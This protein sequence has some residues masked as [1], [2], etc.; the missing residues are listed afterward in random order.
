[1]KF[2]LDAPA[3]INWFLQI[4]GK[5][6]DG[7]HDIVSAMQCVSLEDNISFEDAPEIELVSDLDLPVAEN[8]VYK[9]AALLKRRVSYR[10]GAR[11][12]LRK[13]IPHAAGLGGGSSDA[14][15]TLVGLDRLWGLNLG[16]DVLMGLGSEI[17]SDV[18]FF[19]GGSPLSVVEGRG[20]RV[21]R[22]KA[23]DPLWLLLVKPGIAIPTA[24]AYG[25]YKPELTKKSVDIKLFCH[26][27]DRKDF[28]SLQHIIGNDLEKGVFEKYGV[29][30]EIKRA[31]VD[32]GAVFASMSGSGSAVFGVF[33]SGKEAAAA[34]EHM[35][36][37]WCRVV[38]TLV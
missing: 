28:A 25:A 4:T 1:M 24:W 5:R 26:A 36:K 8:L 38:R 17:G 27:L 37:Y 32:N 21:R 16:E 15:H 14:A 22:L 13:N 23:H 10:R 19:I 11:I 2:S 20:E 31:L 6:S 3:K 7:Y 34:S 18:P 9:A 30:A 29:V 33:P 35:G 12:V